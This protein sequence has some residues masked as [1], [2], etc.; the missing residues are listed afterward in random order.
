[1]A[2]SG[3]P[4]MARRVGHGT[5]Q[6][7]VRKVLLTYWNT[8]AFHVLYA[9]TNGWAPVG[10]A[11]AVHGRPVQDRWLTSQRAQLVRDVTTALEAFDTQRAGGLIAGFVDDLSNWYVRRSRRRF[12]DGDPAALWTLHET[13][14]VL[15][16]LMAPLTPFVTERVWQDIVVS[17]DPDAPHS[18]H[19]ARW[20]TYDESQVDAQLDTGMALTRRVVE[21]GRAARAE[22]KVKTRQPL[23]RALLPSASYSAL[24]EALLAEIGA[25]LNVEA[26]ESFASAGDLV[27]HTAKANFRAL[28]KRFG[29]QTPQVAAAVAAADAERLARELTE[30]G[31]TSVEFE[32]E[33]VSLSADEV[34]LTERPREG[35]SVV[36]EH[37]ETIALDLHLS[38]TLVRA[39]LAREAVRLVQEARKSAGFEVSDR[40]RLRWV[41]E[42]PLAEALREHADLVARE[43]L[44]VDMSEGLTDGLTPVEDTDLGLTF[45]LVRA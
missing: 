22:A 10:E 44:A 21:L 32:G 39:G 30:S 11:P 19:L 15:T 17:V 40:V 16:R 43:V 31:T 12:W 42:G 34:L 4:W 36:N 2:A 35:W 38:P 14:E 33:Q 20:P 3:S 5:L 13:L 28:G 23:S 7:I 8:V 9:R 45:T 41:A 18:V 26:V 27:D 6:E 24:D 37:G 25:E 1:M 29:K